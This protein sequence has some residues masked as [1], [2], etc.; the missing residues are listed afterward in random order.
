MMVL[1]LLD[2]LRARNGLF[3]ADLAVGATVLTLF[4]WLGLLPA[5]GAIIGPGQMKAGLANVLRPDDEVLSLKYTEPS[6]VFYAGRHVDLVRD[7]QQVEQ[8]LATT[9]KF[10]CVVGTDRLKEDEAEPAELRQ[11]LVEVG[12]VS[13]FR[14]GSASGAILVPQAQAR[15]RDAGPARLMAVVGY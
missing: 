11:E 4:V 3:V 10:V 15:R 12:K 8:K 6:V 9:R 13:V 14:L 2:L 7:W 5:I 1:A